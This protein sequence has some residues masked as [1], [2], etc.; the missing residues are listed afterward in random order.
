M[1]NKRGSAFF[2]EYAPASHHG[3]FIMRALPNARV[4]GPVYPFD[5]ALMALPVNATSSFSFCLGRVLQSRRRIKLYYWLH[6]RDQT[7]R[8]AGCNN[9]VSCQLTVDQ[10]ISCFTLILRQT[11]FCKNM[12]SYLA[13]IL[14]NCIFRDGRYIFCKNFVYKNPFKAI[15]IH[16][17]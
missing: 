14:R 10:L 3:E 8:G 4:C 12:T 15:T 9:N 7:N 5:I 11:G 1:Y 16:K 17:K 2:N 13:I 6:I